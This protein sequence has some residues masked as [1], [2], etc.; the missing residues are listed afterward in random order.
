[1]ADPAES[2]Y[3]G[4]TTSHTSTKEPTS[5]PEEG[6]KVYGLVRHLFDDVALLLRKELALAASEINTSVKE[7]KKGAAG[8]LS[9]AVVLNSGYLFLLAAVAIG[10]TNIMAAWMAAL[11]VGIATTIV[12]FVMVQSGKKKLEPSSFKP[13]R[14]MQEFRKDRESIK[15]ATT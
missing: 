14:T 3:T 2:E 11:L 1:M 8:M 10:L 5:Q 4:P 6:A 12:G 13:E 9:G 15:G 7:T